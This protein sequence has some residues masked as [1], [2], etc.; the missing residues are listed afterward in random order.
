MRSGLAWCAAILAGCAFDGSGIDHGARPDADPDA[1]DADR[2]M[3]DADP[4]APDAG[5]IDLGLTFEPAN[6]DECDLPA[7]MGSF[8]FT[9]G[10]PHQIDTSS[11]TIRTGATL[12]TTLAHAV[13]L[14]DG[15]SLQ[16]MVIVAD[17]L[18]VDAN[19]LVQVTGSRPLIVIAKG[20]FAVLGVIDASAAGPIGGPGA[21]LQCFT[22]AGAA[23]ST[24]LGNQLPTADPGGS[25][26]GG[27]AFATVGGTGSRVSPQT[28]LDPPTAGGAVWSSTLTPLVGGCAGGAGGVAVASDTAAAGGGGGGALELVA[29]GTLVI[30]GT[31][32]ASGGGG[33]G[34]NI[35]EAAQQSGG[36]GGGGSGGG[37]LLQAPSV[38]LMGCA[39]TANGGAGGEGARDTGPGTSGG[40]GLTD[41]DVAA[42]GGSGVAGGNGGAGAVLVAAGEAATVGMGDTNDTAGGGGGGG[43]VGRITIRGLQIDSTGGALSSP[44]FTQNPL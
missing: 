23:G 40:D 26:G 19:A 35:G 28:I 21:N 9:A 15:T 18:E 33:R 41:D 37:L 7:S 8:R 5:C 12:V 44:Q 22:G 20:N 3:P 31:V 2:T 17:S 24:Q 13:I 32:S 1:P 34:A 10:E 25:G 38:A 6:V 39:L 36:G 27:G 14:Q 30:E 4:T 11:N 42:Q 16:A 29:G 43:G